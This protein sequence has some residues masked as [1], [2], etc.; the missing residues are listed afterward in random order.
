MRINN[1]EG[2]FNI[3]LAIFG[4]IFSILLV[5]LIV[6]SILANGLNLEIILFSFFFLFISFALSLFS[7]FTLGYNVVDENGITR[8]F[9]FYKKRYNWNDLQFISKSRTYIK[10]SG[11]I[12]EKIIVS[13]KIPKDN[14]KNI[15]IYRMFSK[16]WFYMPY[17]KDLES[18]MIA[19][20]PINCY[21]YSYIV[22]H[23]TDEKF[24]KYFQ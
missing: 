17:S 2:S 19:K 8:C 5:V 24:N 13:V 16:K 6:L 14:F 7:I 3:G 20:S 11:G 22:D 21:T 1:S 23:T 4:L 12:C 18:Y 9:L 10:F 15:H